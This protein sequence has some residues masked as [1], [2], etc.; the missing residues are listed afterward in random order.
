MDLMDFHLLASLSLTRIQKALQ[1]PFKHHPLQPPCHLHLQLKNHKLQQ[2]G[3]V[4][5]VLHMTNHFH[6]YPPTIFFCH[7]CSTIWWY[8]HASIFSFIHATSIF[9]HQHHV[10]GGGNKLNNDRN[11][12]MCSSAMVP[13]DIQIQDLHPHSKSTAFQSLQ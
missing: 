10:F 7:P 6:C 1:L 2:L 3:K 12:E 13:W 4:H 8:K 5:H 11:M 9:L